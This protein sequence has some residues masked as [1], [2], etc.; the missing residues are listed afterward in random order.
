LR[1]KAKFLRIWSIEHKTYTYW[2][3]RPHLSTGPE[4]S[5]NQ[6]EGI[7]RIIGTVPI[8]PDGS[9]NFTAPS[10][11][12]LHFQLL[13]EKQRA[14]QTMKSFTGV[15]PGE[16]RGC[17]GCHEM[18]MNSAQG[19]RIGTAM[20]RR[21]S[22]ITPVAW[23]DITVGYERYVQSGLNQYCGDCHA[24]DGSKAQKAFNSRLR[25]GFLGF[26]EPY[27]TLM[28]NPTWGSP[29][30]NR[31]GTGAFGWADTIL[32]ESY[33]TVD[34]RAYAT[35]PPMKKLSY[36]SRLVKRFA[37]EKVYAGDKHPKI[38]VD[39]ETLLRVKLWVDAM[40]PYS[41]VEELRAKED[42]QFQGRDWISQ[43]PRIQSAPIVQRPGP[44]DVFHPENDPAYAPPDPQQ[45]N[46]LPSGGQRGK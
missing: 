30:H 36:A 19:P 12:A 32:V 34:P 18:H 42:P 28:G 2:Y 16:V 35:Y 23:E 43:P 25:P 38:E 39:E 20:R 7:K 40:G 27:M 10:G 46:A 4:L 8:E 1:G 5:A 14:L 22:A 13:D 26:K 6:S 41:G 21:P 37:N 29:Y 45:Y 17:F 3:K 11:I 44:F 15:Q 24:R 33:S 31:K 9:V